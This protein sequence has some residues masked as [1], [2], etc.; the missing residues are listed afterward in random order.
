MYSLSSFTLDLQAE[1]RR[2]RNV[3]EVHRKQK[4]SSHSK[5]GVTNVQSETMIK[6]CIL[7]ILEHGT[8]PAVALALAIAPNNSRS[9]QRHDFTAPTKRVTKILFLAPRAET[10]ISVTKDREPVLVSTEAR[11]P[12]A[13]QLTA[14]RTIVK[15]MSSNDCMRTSIADNGVGLPTMRLEWKR[16][17]NGF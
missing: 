13:Q 14:Q 1:R 8:V 12:K 15:Q 9:W 16:D 7:H 6:R 10:M 17:L 11:P 3:F 4:P 5:G 2:L